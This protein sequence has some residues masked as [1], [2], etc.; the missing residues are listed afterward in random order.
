MLKAGFTMK[1]FIQEDEGKKKNL[2]TPSLGL[3]TIS[4]SALHSTWFFFRTYAG[5]GKPVSY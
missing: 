2:T 3:A 4:E 1:A 5:L